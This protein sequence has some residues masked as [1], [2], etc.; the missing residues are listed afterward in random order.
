MSS[1]DR[2]ASQWIVPTWQFPIELLVG[3]FVSSSGYYCTSEGFSSDDPWASLWTWQPVMGSWWSVIPSVLAVIFFQL[4]GFILSWSVVCHWSICQ[5]ESLSLVSSRYGGYFQYFQFWR[6]WQISNFVSFEDSFVDQTVNFAVIVSVSGYCNSGFLSSDDLLA[7]QSVKLAVSHQLLVCHIV[8]S[9]GYY[10]N[11]AF[12]SSDD[13][14]AAQSVNLKTYHE[15]LAGRILS[16]RYFLCNWN[17][18]ITTL[19]IW[20]DF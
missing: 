7:G 17:L 12:L 14:W 9:C 20:S 19:M 3:H 4:S 5:N 11:S 10:C 2:L 8:S 15:L 16:S 13:P 1:D 18:G 6:L